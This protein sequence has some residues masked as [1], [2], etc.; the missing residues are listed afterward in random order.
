MLN[1][2]KRKNL[3]GFRFSKSI[4][5]GQG[6]RINIGKRG[7]SISFG[8][9]GAT[10]NV[11]KKGTRTTVGIPGAGVSQSKYSKHRSSEEHQQS[12]GGRGALLISL[13]AIGLILI[14]VF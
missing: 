4:K 12:S 8:R 2:A 10:I 13:I 9:P 7:S 1:K 11:T 14:F 5:I 3:L 6:I